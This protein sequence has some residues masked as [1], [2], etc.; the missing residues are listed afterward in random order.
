MN[1]TYTIQEHWS[2]IKK[3]I[4]ILLSITTFT[5]FLVM[6]FSRQIL[7][8][9]LNYYSVPYASFALETTI[10]AQMNI[11]F[12]LAG[13]IS[14]ALI[15]YYFINVFT[16][17]KL[18]NR[19]VLLITAFL[20][21]LL[22]GF[23]FGI[24]YFS[25]VIFQLLQEMSINPTFDISNL[26]TFGL[27]IG[28]AMAISFSLVL[29]IP[30]LSIYKLINPDWIIKSTPLILFII[31]VFVAWITPTDLTGNFTIM[32]P[33]CCTTAL[34]TFIAKISQREMKTC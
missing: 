30:L 11:S 28:S 15:L 14:S 10:N 25:K 18:N 4:L 26:I 23:L 31:F 3:E 33:M 13:I 12:I 20:T 24:T 19:V 5:F 9:L 7:E 22:S 2:I 32:M 34:G 16:D 1:E 8:W 27:G 17:E 6:T 21:L 29:L